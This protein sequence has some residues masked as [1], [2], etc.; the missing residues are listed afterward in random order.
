MCVMHF[1]INWPLI[2]VCVFVIF[3]FLEVSGV[4]FSSILDALG[5]AGVTLDVQCALLID[6][7]LFWELKMEASGTLNGFPGRSWAYFC[8]PSDKK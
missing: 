3:E 6:F 1:P 4:I 5:V 7:L 8:D 2:S